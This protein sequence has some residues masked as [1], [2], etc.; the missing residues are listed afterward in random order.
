MT[1]QRNQPSN[2]D[3]VVATTDITG[4]VLSDAKIGREAFGLLLL[5]FGVLGCLGAPGTLHW[6]AGLSAALVGLC[7]SGVLVRR[8]SKHRW[9]LS[10]TSVGLATPSCQEAPYS[11]LSGPG[12]A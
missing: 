11:C 4:S 10:W 1:T 9:R 6:A 8:N 2:D 7:A 3:P 5:S 12:H